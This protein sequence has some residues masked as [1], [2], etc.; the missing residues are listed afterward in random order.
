MITQANGYKRNEVN[1]SVQ[2]MNDTQL[3]K[4]MQMHSGSLP[5]QTETD[6][7]ITGY[8]LMLC[9][10]NVLAGAL[11]DGG[12]R[13]RYNGTNLCTFIYRRLVQRLFSWR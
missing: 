11:A 12:W 6:S 5:R 1:V 7:G 2:C 4:P 10:R 3:Q 9:L 13:G 8:S